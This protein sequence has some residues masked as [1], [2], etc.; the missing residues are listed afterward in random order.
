MISLENKLVIAISSRAVF[1]FE[2]ENR[3]FEQSDDR[4]Y[5]ALQRERLDQAA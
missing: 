2:E 3:V 1:D 4:A 5:R